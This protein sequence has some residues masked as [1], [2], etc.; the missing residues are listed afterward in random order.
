MNNGT[1]SS[2]TVSTSNTAQT[3]AQLGDLGCNL[4]CALSSDN[5]TYLGTG[6]NTVSEVIMTESGANTGVF[7][8]FDVN[9][10][11]QFN[12]R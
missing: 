11:G 7:E 6:L 8:S 10:N 4:N 5:E 3:A 9:G 1:Y 2:G 12:N